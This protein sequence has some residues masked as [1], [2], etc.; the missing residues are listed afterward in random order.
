[1]TKTI[2]SLPKIFRLLGCCIV[3]LLLTGCPVVIPV[4]VDMAIQDER[5]EVNQ[6]IKSKTNP[7]QFTEQ[8]ARD[9]SFEIDS[10]TAQ[11]GLREKSAAMEAE[12]QKPKEAQQA[13]KFNALALMPGKPKTTESI[14]VTKPAVSTANQEKPVK[15]QRVESPPV[16]V[17]TKVSIA[18]RMYGV[19]Q[20]EKA[21]WYFNDDGTARIRIPS[22][23][24][25]GVATTYIRWK[26]NDSEGMIY[27]TVTRATLEGSDGFDYDREMD[28]SLT[29]PI[30]MD[31]D[32]LVINVERLHRVQSNFYP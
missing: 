7:N 19:W 14:E 1:M 9:A 15:P 25:Q 12:A 32:E 29:Q 11:Q 13:E 4:L 8:P 23:N 18:Q 16:V 21:T 26:V 30:H 6:P 5:S 20:N 10:E 27:Y 2:F 22:M 31:G 28:R 24:G 17:P 3:T